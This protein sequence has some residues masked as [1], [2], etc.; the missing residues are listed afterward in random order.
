M[1][2]TAYALARRKQVAATVVKALK[3]CDKKQI[4][5]FCEQFGI[6]KAALK[7]DAFGAIS[8]R[9]DN[10][11]FLSFFEGEDTKAPKP[12]DNGDKGT[13][14]EKIKEILTL[15]GGNFMRF[16]AAAKALLGDETPSKKDDIIAALEA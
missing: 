3:G 11:N 15:S 12:E 6:E 10:Q 8:R 9:T 2:A 16:K 1:S 7:D 5:A 14:A 13:S 4:T